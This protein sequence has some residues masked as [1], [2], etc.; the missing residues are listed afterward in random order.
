M[1]CPDCDK[2]ITIEDFTDD[3]P[4]KCHHCGI[5]LKLEIDESSYCGASQT[6]LVVQD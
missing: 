4:F 6:T 2:W 5:T 3:T 1:D